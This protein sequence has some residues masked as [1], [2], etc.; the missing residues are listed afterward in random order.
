MSLAPLLKYPPVV[1]LSPRSGIQFLDLG[2]RVAGNR[3]VNTQWSFFDTP[4]MPTPRI[5]GRGGEEPSGRVSYDV[6]WRKVTETFGR[7]WIPVPFLRREQAGGHKD[8]PVNWARAQVVPLSEPDEQGNDYRLVLAFDTNIAEKHADMAYLAPTEEDTRLGAQFGLAG[9]EPTLS[10][11]AGRDWIQKWCRKAYTEMILAE[12]RRRSKAEPVIDEAMIKERL[13]GPREDVA[14]FLALLDFL[15]SL[16]IT[17]NLGLID[18]SSFPRSAPIDVDLVLDLGNSRTCGL[19]IETHPDETSA[20]LAQAVRLTL[21]DLGFPERQYGD[22]FDS[23]LEFNRASVGW[24]DI[25]FL[26]GR[27]DAFSWPTVARVGVEAQRLAAMRRGS[28]GATGMSSPKRY[29]WDD[30]QRRDGWRFNAPDS[31]GASPYAMGVEFT[32]LVNDAGE[33]LHKVPDGLP[34]NDDARFPA[35]RALYTRSHL[36]SFS[37]A[38]ILLQAM[39]MMNSISHRLRRGNAE[40]PR[41]L[42]RVILTA[43][44]GMPQSERQILAERARAARDLI[45]I[46]LDLAEIIPAS[47]AEGKERI[48]AT[49]ADHPLPEMIIKW[50]EASATQA[51]YLYSQVAMA[52][53]GDA[54]ACFRQLR[55]PGG[56]TVDGGARIATLDIGG[57]TTDLVIT[58]YTVD[59]HGANVTLF[60]RQILTEGVSLAG[61]DVVFHLIVEHVLGP[62]R[63]ALRE[64][65]S[66]ERVDS[67]MSRMFG[68]NRGDMDVE[69]QLRRQ[70]FASHIGL[71]LVLRMIAAYEGWDRLSGEDRRDPMRISEVVGELIDQ[72]LVARLDKEI[73]QQGFPDFSIR[74]IAFEVDLREIDR[75]ARS[76]LT[77]TLRAF[78]ELVRRQG[79]DVM[80]LSGRPSRMPAVRDILVETCGLPPHRIQALHEFRVGQWYPFRDHEAHIADPKT[81]AAVGAMICMLGEG[82]LRNFNFRSDKL[83]AR[84]T[85]RYF[86]KLDSNNRL[87]DQDVFLADLDFDNPEYEVPQ[88]TF[89]FRTPMSLGI[90]QFA[91]DWWPGTRLY[92]IDYASPEIAET[93]NKRTPLKVELQRAQ[94]RGG[95]GVIDGLKIRRVEDCEGRALA[96]NQVR[97]WLQTIDNHEG[98]WLDTGVLLE[99]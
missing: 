1:W 40:L 63:A 39:C 46:C 55:L 42:R 53:S 26:S 22:P 41:R 37:L 64:Q 19:L 75:T 71:P 5:V 74:D 87:A 4:E 29:L 70:Q 33:P 51:A 6:D 56:Q 49:E 17:P 95:K 90:R 32:T 54:L 9:D 80:I 21:R 85:A 78:A 10:W 58:E 35:M 81:T 83:Q 34:I 82:R 38:E 84:S 93:L 31:V 36:M 20:D 73:R 65:G 24:D 94:G 14:R 3:E 60:P 8:G 47:Q 68:G 59:G 18:R 2:F 92:S 16:K 88:Q 79:A 77:D 99:D 76:V 89:E 27:A 66:E 12:E 28:E 67:L 23:R 69:D 25:S 13:E 30:V 48:A 97:M 50:D 7:V 57:G 11:F 15:A 61:D 44:T 96:T 62:I 91:V 98:Y 86:G 52:F 72:T 43:P 45:Y